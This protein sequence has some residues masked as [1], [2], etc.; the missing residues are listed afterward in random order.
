MKQ[1]HI[2]LEEETQRKIKL[3]ADKKGMKIYRLIREIVDYYIKHENIQLEE[4]STKESK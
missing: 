3:L 4:P 1:T 2:N